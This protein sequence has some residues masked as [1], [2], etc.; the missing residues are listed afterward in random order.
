MLLLGR[1]SDNIG[2]PEHLNYFNIDSLCHLLQRC[3]F[4]I[5]ETLTPGRLDVNIVRN[6]IKENET[7]LLANPF[8]KYI[9]TEAKDEAIDSFQRFLSKNRLSSH[10]WVV[11]Q[12]N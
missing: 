5:I 11:A 8:M 3:G 4:S 6:K 2:G 12:K 1:L 9:L 10:M 7:D